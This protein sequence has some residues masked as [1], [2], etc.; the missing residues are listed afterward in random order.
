MPNLMGGPNGGAGSLPNPLSGGIGIAPRAAVGAGAAT[1]SPTAPSG[2]PSTSPTQSG[3]PMASTPGWTPPQPQ[4]VNGAVVGAPPPPGLTPDQLAMYKSVGWY[5]PTLS[6]IGMSP[7][8]IATIQ[9]NAPAQPAPGSANLPPGS[10][11]TADGHP[12]FAAQPGQLNA[13]GGAAPGSQLL[14]PIGNTINPQLSNLA[15]F[16][17][18]FSSLQNPTNASAQIASSLSP[19]DQTNSLLAIMLG[20]G[21]GY[22]PYGLSNYTRQQ[23]Q[24][25]TFA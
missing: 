21:G 11:M 16:L 20:G 13:N 7:T 24:W 23:L 14:N 8:D 5:T 10:P 25:P 18:M 17:Q 1:G 9:A 12:Y 4:G 15:Q 2:S 6:Q 22:N 19:G 3:W